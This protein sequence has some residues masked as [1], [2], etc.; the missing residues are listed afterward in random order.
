ML[1]QML[2][3]SQSS[4]EDKEAKKKTNPQWYKT[5]NT[6]VD[7]VES[8]LGSIFLPDA[9]CFF[10]GFP[11]MEPSFA[12]PCHHH[13]SS[14]PLNLINESDFTPPTCLFPL[15]PVSSLSCHVPHV[16]VPPCLLSHSSACWLDFG[17]LS[18]TPCVEKGHNAVK[19]LCSHW[20]V[21]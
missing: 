12:I 19:H 4:G 11:T 8:T 5:I 10:F 20:G 6:E 3:K 9:P 7:D 1:N 15:F 14:P 21:H 16:M 18:T 2:I 17:L 13:C